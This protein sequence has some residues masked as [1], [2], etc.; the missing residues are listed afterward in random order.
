VTD[1]AKSRSATSDAASRAGRRQR[2]RLRRRQKPLRKADPPA[3][4][5]TTGG[6][7][8]PIAGHRSGGG[9]GRFHGGVLVSPGRGTWPRTV[10]RARA[11]ISTIAAIVV[12]ASGTL[13]QSGRHSASE[14]E[15]RSHVIAES[16]GSAPSFHSKGL[17]YF[18]GGAPQRSIAELDQSARPSRSSSTT[19]RLSSLASTS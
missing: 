10:G 16:D 5:A 11:A 1:Y 17:D 6:R 14:R 19:R 13:A 9:S 4:A 7:A 3:P 15:S 2:P 18:E 8:S 12:V